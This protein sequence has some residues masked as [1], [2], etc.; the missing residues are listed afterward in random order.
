MV[1]DNWEPGE[2]EYAWMRNLL[3]MVKDGGVWGIP[4]ALSELTF[5]MEKKEYTF[6]GDRDHELCRRSFR[7]LDHLGWKEV[8]SEEG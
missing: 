6:N 3:S 5:D 2:P 8:P 4:A 7:V 1:E